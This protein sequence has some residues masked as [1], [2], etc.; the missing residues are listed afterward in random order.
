MLQARINWP[1]QA[2]ALHKCGGVAGKQTELLVWE[3]NEQAVG[4]SST[5]L[6]V[7]TGS[8]PSAEMRGD[9][10]VTQLSYYWDNRLFLT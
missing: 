10:L 1:V 7:S 2:R 4:T 5:A 6:A 9:Q 8:K 3:G